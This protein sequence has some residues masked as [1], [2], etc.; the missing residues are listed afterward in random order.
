ME[1]K[2]RPSTLDAITRIVADSIT[3]PVGPEYLAPAVREG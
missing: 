1:L 2:L 3:D